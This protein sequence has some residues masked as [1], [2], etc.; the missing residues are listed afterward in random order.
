MVIDNYSWTG[1]AEKEVHHYITGKP[2]NQGAGT[3]YR[4]FQKEH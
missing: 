1:M 3:M 4:V 2:S